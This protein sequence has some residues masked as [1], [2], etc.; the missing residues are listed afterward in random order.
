MRRFAGRREADLFYNAELLRLDEAV[1][2]PMYFD[3]LR[4]HLRFVRI[5]SLSLVSEL[6]MWQRD[7]PAI[8]L[9]AYSEIAESFHMSGKSSLPYSRQRGD[10]RTKL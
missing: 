3:S 5:P 1:L 2:L 7:R 6:L 9:P 10:P 8:D 4:E